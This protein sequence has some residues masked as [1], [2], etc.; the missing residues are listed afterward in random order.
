MTYT[1]FEMQPIPYDLY[2]ATF[3]G[4]NSMQV[5]VQTFDDGITKEVQ[6][7]EV[8]YQS[9]WTQHPIEFSKYIHEKEKPV[10]PSTS[11][12]FFSKFPLL[13]E[14]KKIYDID[15]Y[16][17][18]QLRI[19]LEQKDGVGPDVILPHEIYTNKLKNTNFNVNRLKKFLK[20]TE[21]RIS[22]ILSLNAGNTDIFNLTKSSKFPFSTG[23]ITINTQND[24]FYKDLKVRSVIFSTNKGNLLITVHEKSK[25]LQKCVLYLW[26]LSGILKEPIKNLIAP[27]NVSMGQFRGG[28]DGIIVAALEDG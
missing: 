17:N 12:D 16:N 21:S 7:E 10:Q 19:F 8:L 28:T 5:A 25:D 22:N 1:L 14:D 13:Q 20:K 27:D 15:V 2:M 26:D 11:D 23:Y 3:G 9:K 6:T 4:R 24:M 18:N